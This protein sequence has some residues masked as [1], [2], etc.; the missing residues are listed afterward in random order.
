MGLKQL[1]DSYT[2]THASIE[3]V[4]T[5]DAGIP[6]PVAQDMGRQ[7]YLVFNLRCENHTFE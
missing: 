3:D 5:G 4:D 7:M 2:H 1:K 6:V